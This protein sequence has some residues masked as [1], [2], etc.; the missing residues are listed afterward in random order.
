MGKSSHWS[1]ARQSHPLQ[2]DFF[3]DLD[4]S[5]TQFPLHQVR[6]FRDGYGGSVRDHNQEAKLRLRK[7]HLNIIPYRGRRKFHA[8][9][10]LAKSNCSSDSGPIGRELHDRS[11]SS[12]PRW[13][14]PPSDSSGR[15]CHHAIRLLRSKLRHALG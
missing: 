3:R 2:S 10:E 15:L 5:A 12:T 9:P 6:G 4:T 8:K 1:S 7:E 13:T 11:P 14:T